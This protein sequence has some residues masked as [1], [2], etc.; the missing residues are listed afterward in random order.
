MVGGLEPGTPAGA[1]KSDL[2]RTLDL[3]DIL[4]NKHD[5][6]IEYYHYQYFHQRVEQ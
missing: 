1:P 6:I 4:R 5:L 2:E 3:E